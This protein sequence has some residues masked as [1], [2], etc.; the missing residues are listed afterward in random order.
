MSKTTVKTT[1]ESQVINLM[2][3]KSKDIYLSDLVNAW[4]E[5]QDMAKVV[6]MLRLTNEHVNTIKNYLEKSY[7]KE[8]FV[9]N[10]DEYAGQWTYAINNKRQ[11]FLTFLLATLIGDKEYRLSNKFVLKQENNRPFLQEMDEFDN[12]DIEI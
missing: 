12:L 5:Y 8:K 10:R 3:T 11:K 9:E 2:G 6:E 4:K 7:L 1:A